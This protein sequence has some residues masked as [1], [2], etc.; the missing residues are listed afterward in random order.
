[1]QPVTDMQIPLHSYQI[2][3]KNF[4]LTHPYCG[5]FLEMGLGKTSIVLET[6]WEL[7]P[8]YHVLIIAPKNIAKVTWIN[9]IRKWNMNIRWQS[10]IVNKRGK[11]LTKEKRE[12]IYASIPENQNATVYFINR[13]LVKDLVDHFP[14]KKWP[15]KMIVIDESQSFKSYNAVRFKALQSIRNYT[16]RIILLTGSPAPQGL[17]DLWP[18]IYL[19][20]G[21]V[22]LGRNITTF[23]NAFCNPGRLGPNGYPIEWI[24]K[25]YMFMNNGYPMLNEYGQIMSAKDVIYENID[26]IVISMKN[27]YIQLP[28]CTYTNDYV[29]MSD[30]EMKIYKEFMKNNIIELSNGDIVE[31]SNAAVLQGKLS[32]IASGAIYYNPEENNPHGNRKYQIIHKQKLEMCDY[33]VRNTASPVIVAYQF[34]SDLD[35]LLKYFKQHPLEIG[36]KK[37]EAQK[38]DG[39]PEMEAAWNKG[40][41]PLMLIQPA[42]CGFGLNFQA[43]GHTLIWYTIPWSLEQ[44]EQTNA[45]IYRQG[46]EQPVI[47]HHIMTKNT[48]DPRILQ[49]INKKSMSQQDLINAIEATIKECETN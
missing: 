27:K 16:E 34:K 15:F 40:E 17:E 7:N 18:Q 29:E 31:A 8:S 1:M 37:Y 42:S 41:I 26:D 13:E 14:D 21:G 6:L 48:I 44:Y 49:A 9:E 25:P 3:A 10:L 20:D 32:Q 2:F 35:M 47:I 46:Q 45:R 28:S 43:G 36:N 23:R 5:L 30:D 39:T 38:F 22:R 4:A 19:L 12:E 24:P 33:I 11:N